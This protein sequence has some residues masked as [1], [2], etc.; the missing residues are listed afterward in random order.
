[1]SVQYE[2]KEFGK[3]G[4][5][6]SGEKFTAKQIVPESVQV[7]NVEDLLEIL[8]EVSVSDLSVMT[9]MVILGA[10]KY[11]KNLAGGSD[12]ASKLAAQILKLGQAAAF[13]WAGLSK[14]EI[15]SKIRSGKAA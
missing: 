13:G 11:L 6:N 14:A 15:A 9:N 3:Q 7:S 4:K 10:N 1:M 5:G 2:E 8:S 12:E